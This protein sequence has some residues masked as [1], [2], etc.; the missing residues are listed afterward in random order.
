[1]LE[2]MLKFAL[3]ALVELVAIALWMTGISVAMLVIGSI[4]ITIGG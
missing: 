3:V 2:R 1:M 4:I